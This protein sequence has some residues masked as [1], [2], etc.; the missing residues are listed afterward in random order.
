MK[1]PN[2]NSKPFVGIVLE[3]PSIKIR[4]NACKNT[5]SPIMQP[6][7]GPHITTPLQKT[8]SITVSCANQVSRYHQPTSIARQTIAPQVYV[9]LSPPYTQI[10]ASTR[11]MTLCLVSRKTS[12]V[13]AHT[14]IFPLQV[15]KKKLK[16]DVS[17]RPM[18]ASDIAHY[19]HRRS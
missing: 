8:S 9:Y 5:P 16:S 2:A 17:V 19:L 1:T 10:R 4:K 12:A 6:S 13:I 7:A 11:Q 3:T 14:D 18:E 15:I